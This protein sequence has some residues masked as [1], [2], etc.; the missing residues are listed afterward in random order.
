M[1]GVLPT[2][3]TRL[4]TMWLG[5]GGI[6]PDSRARGAIGIGSESSFAAG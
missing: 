2:Q 3:M 1:I 4:A 5:L 6:V